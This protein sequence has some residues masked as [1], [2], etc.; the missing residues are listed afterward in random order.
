MPAEEYTRL[1]NIQAR[2]QIVC[3]QN[4]HALRRLFRANI[5]DLGD[6][7]LVKYGTRVHPGEGYALRIV[8]ESTA[9]TLLP[10][11]FDIVTDDAKNETY[12]IQQKLPGTL[13]SEMLFTNNPTATTT[14]T[15]T[16]DEPTLLSIAS[17][18]R[19][20]LAELSKLD[21][22]GKRLGLVGR[23]GC[24]DHGVLARYDMRAYRGGGCMEGITT[25]ERFVRWIDE[26]PMHGPSRQQR[27]DWIKNFQFHLPTMFSHGDLQPENI[28]IDG[29]HLSGIIDWENAGWYPY[30]WNDYM[31][32]LKWDPKG[33]WEK[34][35]LPIMME[36]R[37]PKE[38]LAFRHLEHFA[39]TCGL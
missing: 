8:R 25:T 9:T 4:P 29:G 31:A 22:D 13:L 3:A 19:T 11:V 10:K 26:Y 5:V 6:G 37:Y 30:F 27:D 17:E 38:V 33:Q 15:T 39:D 36:R 14:T 7:T 35:V 21:G 12:I 24:F 2:I 23:D 20:F 18:L 32:T 1:R 28:L 16:I 34:V